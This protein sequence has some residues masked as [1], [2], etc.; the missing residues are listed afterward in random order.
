MKF[1][2][3][4]PSLKRRISAR[5]SWKR[6]VRHRMGL[7]MP[8]GYGFVTNPK[9]FA[10]N[11][12][13]NK[14]SFSVD[15]LF[16]VGHKKTASATNLTNTKISGSTL[17]I[18]LAV[19]LLIAFWPIGLALTIYLI[20]KHYNKGK[21]GHQE[22]S[23]GSYPLSKVSSIVSTSNS[24]LP[25]NI[26]IPEP[27]KSLLWATNE[28][29]SKIESAA[30]IKLTVELGVDGVN[31]SNSKDNPNFFAEPSLIWTR[32]SIEPNDELEKEPMYY[33]SY[34]GLSP[35]HR[36]QYLNWLKDI[37]QE[38]NLS[39]VFLYFYGLERHLLV[40]NYDLAV[41]EILRLL[42][43]HSKGTFKS[44]AIHSLIAGSVFRKRPDIVDKAPFILED[45]SDLALALK[46]LRQQSL[47][48][49]DLIAISSRVR[50]HNKRYIKAQPD[51]FEKELQAKIDEYE[52]INSSLLSQFDNNTIA[53][54]NIMV[55]ANLSIPDKIRTVKFPALL[56]DEKFKTTINSLLLNTHNKIKEMKIRKS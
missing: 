27:T 5:V 13:Y 51:L 17:L 28:N 39:Y 16:K 41:D 18:I 29:T 8:R 23:S 47:S 26:A 56:E 30:T 2:L 49:K 35:K 31:I 9:K 24:N 44:Y 11:K 52:K 12:V 14:T 54:D 55:F 34:S 7:K 22:T 43:F 10:Y 48:A 6:A 32:L 37:T 19:I 20:V 42:K 53:K 1:G 33:P 45:T 40:G 25:A 4:T 21:E 3:R 15:R 36:F 50:F 46:V 38:T